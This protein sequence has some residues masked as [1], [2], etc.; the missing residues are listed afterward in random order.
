MG[1]RWKVETLKTVGD[2]L[3]GLNLGDLHKNEQR[4]ARTHLNRFLEQ[5]YG[6]EGQ[7]DSIDNETAA[8]EYVKS[9]ENILYRSQFDE[10]VHLRDW[11]HCYFQVLREDSALLHRCLR[12]LVSAERGRVKVKAGRSQANTTPDSAQDAEQ[13]RSTKLPYASVAYTKDKDRI[14]GMPR[15][16]GIKRGR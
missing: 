3:K 2:A 16:S 5:K 15:R 12:K 9:I 4:A 13:G 8:K 11:E 6:Q 7:L 14:E 1:R 10:T